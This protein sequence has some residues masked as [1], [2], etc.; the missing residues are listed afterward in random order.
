M[1]V[2]VYLFAY[3]H[4]QSPEVQVSSFGRA[5]D[6]AQ[7]SMAGFRKHIVEITDPDLLAGGGKRFCPTLLPSDDPSDEVA[8]MRYAITDEELVAVD[9]YEACGYRREE[10]TLKSGLAAWVYFRL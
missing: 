3:G 5:L 4:L 9:I 1:T 6:G 10:R 8:G 7:D 2:P